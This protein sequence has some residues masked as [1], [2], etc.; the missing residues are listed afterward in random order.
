VSRL[1]KDDLNLWNVYKSNLNKIKK[2]IIINNSKATDKL[3]RKKVHL[4]ANKNL[5]FDKHLIISLKKKK[6]SIQAFIDL[7]GLHKFEA[8]R[9]VTDFIKNSFYK[10]RRHLLIITGKGVDNKGILK[11]ETPNWL[12][13][14]YISRFIVGF[15]TMPRSSGGDGAIYVKVKNVEKYKTDDL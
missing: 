3:E 12:N 4:S 10:K 13:E 9:K 14:P 11:T 1:S 2:K 6:I 15:T 7:H 5:F 8:R